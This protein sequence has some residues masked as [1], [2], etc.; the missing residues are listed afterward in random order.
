M[1]VDAKARPLA[2]GQCFFGLLVWY[3]MT[4]IGVP[5]SEAITKGLVSVQ[6]AKQMAE[7]SLASIHST[8]LLHGRP[9]IDN[10]FFLGGNIRFSGFSEARSCSQEDLHQQ[11]MKELLVE[12]E[13]LQV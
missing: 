2:A 11:E 12:L 13:T 9:S 4:P 1:Q 3:A 10:I 7:V 5:I 6:D 8:Q